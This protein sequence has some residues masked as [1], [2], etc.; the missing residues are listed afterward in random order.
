MVETQYEAKITNSGLPRPAIC[1]YRTCGSYIVGNVGAGII[2]TAGT[3][4]QVVANAAGDN[5]EITHL[6]LI[7]DEAANDFGLIYDGDVATGTLIWKKDLAAQTAYNEEAALKLCTNVLG[8]FFDTETDWTDAGEKLVA[9]CWKK[10]KKR[11][12]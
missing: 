6:S 12:A 3:G 10:W 5:I 11:T 7:H 2:V 1:P 8:V 9:V 4:V